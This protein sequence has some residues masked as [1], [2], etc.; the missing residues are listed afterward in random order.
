MDESDLS[1]GLALLRHPVLPLAIMVEFLYLT[2][3]FATVAEVI[4]ELPAPIETAVT[5]YEKPQQLLEPYSDCFTVLETIKQGGGV[6]TVLNV[7]GGRLDSMAA[8]SSICRQRI[9]TWELERINSLFCGPCGCD[10]CCVGPSREMDQEFFEIPLADEEIAHFEVERLDSVDSRACQAM[11]EAELQLGGVSFY[12]SGTVR[13]IHWQHGWSL[14]L[15]KESRCPNHDPI[16]N[17][18]RIYPDR[19][20]VCRRPQIFPYILEELADGTFRQRNMVLAIIDCP[21]V[22]RLRDDIAA[23]AAACE[24]EIIFKK[25]KG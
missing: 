12:Q 10:L 3:P 21:Y 1:A 15:P 20:L 6:Q 25:N 14:I 13:L 8:A 9:L 7:A 5:L 2:G 23:Y 16:A 19:P 22:R 24:L 4:A 18:C 17:D 11:D